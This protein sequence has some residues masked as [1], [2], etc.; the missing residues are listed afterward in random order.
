MDSIDFSSDRPKKRRIRWLLTIVFALLAITVS[1]WLE[2]SFIAEIAVKKI[3]SDR[4]LTC[5]LSID[6]L[7]LNEI[8]ANNIEIHGENEAPIEIK[9]LS[10]GLDWIKFLSPSLTSVHVDRVDIT[11]DARDGQLRV[12]LLE[13]FQGSSSD[14]G[15]SFELPPFA[16][17]DGELTVL[18]DAGPLKGTLSTSGSV[19]REVQ[20][21]LVIHPAKL[22][23][24]GN[25]ID[26]QAADA[27]FVVNGRQISGHAVFHL[28]ELETADARADS[29]ML[30]GDLD[31]TGKDEYALSW[32]V[33]AASGAYHDVDIT[34]A[35]TSGNMSLSM[36]GEEI[37]LDAVRLNA[38]DSEMKFDQLN[39]GGMRFSGAQASIELS[40]ETDGLSGPVS[41]VSG[42]DIEN[43]VH[44][45]SV[46][47]SGNLALDGRRLTQLAGGFHGA[48]SSERTKVEPGFS[49]PILAALELP[50]PFAAHGGAMR[51][52]FQYLLNDFSTGAEFDLEFSSEAESFGI[53]AVRPAALQ[54]HD[55][56]VSVSVRPPRDADWLRLNTDRLVLAGDWQ[57]DD[58]RTGLEVVL[59]GLMLKQSSGDS[60]TDLTI[61][62]ITFPEHLEK[63][64]RLGFD[65]LDFTYARS[66]TGQRLS[67][68]GQLRLTGPAFGMDLS[69]LQLAAQLEGYEAGGGWNLRFRDDKCMKLGF[70]KASLPA[71]DFGPARM[72]I[73]S[74]GRLLYTRKGSA[75]SGALSGQALRVPFKAPAARGEIDLVSPHYAWTLDDNFALTLSGRD[76]SVPMLIADSEKDESQKGVYSATDLEAGLSTSSEALNVSFEMK[77]GLLA[78]EDLPVNVSL[79][80]ISGKGPIGD[81]GPDIAF[82]LTGGQISDR[83]NDK[84]NALYQ[85]LLFGGAGKMTDEKITL[86]ARVELAKLK[87]FVGD[88]R[89]EHL[90][91]E[92][93]GTAHLKDGSIAFRR[94]GLQLYDVSELLR[95]LAVN[96]SG[97]INPE[98]FVSWQD[99]EL[100]SKGTIGIDNLTFSTFR[101]GKID[102]LSGRLAF[103]DL[104]GLVTEPDQMLTVKALEF[105]PTIVLRNGEIHLAILGPDRFELESA[106]WPFVGGQI[107]MEPTV[108][109]LEGESQRVTV[110]ADDWELA[111]L[112]NLF[113]VPDLKVEGRVSG[114]FP[115][116]IIG[117]NA[118]FRN[119]R[120]SATEAGYF[121]YK[122]DLTETAGQADQY[123]KMAF[124][125]LSNF[126][127]RVMSLSANGNLTGKI[128]LEMELSG[129]NPDLLEGQVF[130]F[131]VSLDSDLAQLVRAGSLTSS[132]DAVQGVIVDLV[133]ENRGAGSN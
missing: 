29:I 118:F 85:P 20:G 62:E 86:D 114:E 22:E 93:R 98:A 3:C 79:A 117:A 18:T 44:S 124:D 19:Q 11:V 80:D 92:N 122:S 73:C 48:V 100:A 8:R 32:T 133:K 107:S 47:V 104:I 89:V 53:S 76:L 17:T 21:K 46:L 75:L 74:E 66:D 39:Y 1:I 111:Q 55:E 116:E 110:R 24:N 6:R 77:N 33:T 28:A 2:R 123:S 87:A 112:M 38:V 97:A 64:I 5:G 31:N 4:G 70:I 105:T 52:S 30:Q 78:L 43:T 103:T 109:D 131:N 127:Y 59:T 54:S 101:L 26:L 94:D 45:D 82:T 119:A 72:E 96:A 35:S 40:P 71:A 27:S 41:L 14:S 42:L 128:I 132:S 69:S 99:G 56:Q 63:G 15:S 57:L 126:Q 68:D 84:D 25:R 106:R 108:W 83:L 95:G 60:R 121:S 12:P 34:E 16:I 37:S 125:A 13:K 129:R 7:S 36:K 90:I 120:L 91:S 50:D 49:E 9:R 61:R 113:E 23:L 65:L 51:S 58:T 67:V 130:N 115:I 10:L 102:G 88:L 81:N